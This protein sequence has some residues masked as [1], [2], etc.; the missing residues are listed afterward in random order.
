MKKVMICGSRTISNLS[1]VMIDEID[2]YIGSGYTILIGDCT[3]VDKLVQK[4]LYDRKYE[5]VHVLYTGVFPRN[6]YPNGKSHRVLCPKSCNNKKKRYYY[7]DKYM[8][9]KS[10]ILFV[11]WDGKSSGSGTSIK[12]AL[13]MESIKE[14]KI[15]NTLRGYINSIMKYGE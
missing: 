7:R 4:Y 5:E 1:G 12:N 9:S 13:N 6:M 2:N 3:G 14:V 10:D 15:V 8:L 11:I